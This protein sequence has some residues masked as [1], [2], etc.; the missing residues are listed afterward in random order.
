MW[1][2]LAAGVLTGRYNEGNK[3]EGRFT[4]DTTFFANHADR[5]LSQYFAPERREAF[6]K[7]LKSLG[8]LAAELGYTQSQLALAWAL[9]N[10]DVSTLIL[11]FSKVT[12]IDENLKALELYRKWT[13]EI[14]AK[15]N[16]IF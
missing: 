3:V 16:E 2:P 8:D 7:K 1:G 12:Y 4:Q 13:P 5:Y 10:K 15:V 6:T 11:G 14:E 9:S